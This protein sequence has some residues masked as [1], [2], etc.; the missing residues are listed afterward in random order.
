MRLCLNLLLHSTRNLSHELYRL[1]ERLSIRVIVITFFDHRH[2]NNN[3]SIT[4]R[5]RFSSVRNPS[6]FTRAPSASK[7]GT[8]LSIAAA[9]CKALSTPVAGGRECGY[10]C[11]YVCGCDGGGGLLLR[12]RACACA[13]PGGGLLLRG[14]AAREEKV[15]GAGDKLLFQGRGEERPG[16]GDERRKR[17]GEGEGVNWLVVLDGSGEG[18]EVWRWRT[19]CKSKAAAKTLTPR[20]RGAC[21]AA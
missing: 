16:P 1:R 8:P 2:N 14:S 17:V 20:C 4:H 9:A 5:A 15:A 18:V 21:C 10:A 11:A 3:L 19:D 12:A 7:P 13:R 6:P